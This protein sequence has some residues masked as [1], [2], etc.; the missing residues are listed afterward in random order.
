[1]SITIIVLIMTPVLVKSQPEVRIAG[2]L[3]NIMANGDLRSTITL[4][5][6]KNYQHLYALGAI[7]GLAG[8]I[9]VLDGKIYN[10]RVKDKKLI[11]DD[12][13]SKAALLVYTDNQHWLPIEIKIL[14]NGTRELEKIISDNANKY[15]PGSDKPIPFMIKGN[16][17]SLRWHVINAPESYEKSHQ[18]FMQ[19]G[20]Q[21]ELKNQ[22]SI[23]LG[24]YSKKHQGVFTHQS[25]EVHIHFI[26][27]DG[28][29][30]GHV[31]DLILDEHSVL[32]IPE[33]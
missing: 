1:M 17:P 29:I 31:D 5:N 22:N 33:K 15:Y 19:S 25:S 8:E 20:L 2:Q 28:K 18:G 32:Y 27:K 23:L 6:L 4:D 13:N 24:F 14:V 26:T 12:H 7:E 3:H 30:S 21:G 9:I 11:I 10:S 16:I